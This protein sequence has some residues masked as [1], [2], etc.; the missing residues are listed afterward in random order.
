[1][2]AALYLPRRHR[3][4]LLFPPGLLALAGLLWLGCVAVPRMQ[5]TTIHSV[6][7]CAVITEYDTSTAIAQDFSEKWC[8]AESKLFSTNRFS[9]SKSIVLTGYKLSDFFALQTIY[10]TINHM[11][12]KPNISQKLQ[13]SFT[14][15]ARY[16][17]LI[18]VIDWCNTHNLNKHWISLRHTPTTLYVISESAYSGPQPP[19][20]QPAFCGTNDY[21]A[22]QN[23]ATT[24][25]LHHLIS[26]WRNTT[27]L[28]LFLT[29]LSAWKLRRQWRAVAS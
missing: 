12:S 14:L 3:R 24:D 21:H 20:L 16:E 27:L 18:R 25:V 22:S 4:H 8:T 17:N 11:Y 23:L 2:P 9:N 5:G 15:N 26:N 19:E 29:A 7:E 13:I 28:L 1:M 10:S 6:I